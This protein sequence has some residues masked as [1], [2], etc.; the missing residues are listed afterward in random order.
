MVFNSDKYNNNR[1]QRKARKCAEEDP[2]HSTQ[3]QIKNYF[4]GIFVAIPGTSFLVGN[5]TANGVA[6]EGAIG[7]ESSRGRAKYGGS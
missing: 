1:S 5:N 6:K 7:F 3:R 4:R 2:S